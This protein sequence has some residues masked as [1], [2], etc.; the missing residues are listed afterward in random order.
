MFRLIVLKGN[1]MTSRWC[2]N[3]PIATG[4][5]AWACLI[6]TQPLENLCQE[7]KLL[8]I[9]SKTSTEN[10]STPY[11]K[12]DTLF[13][14]SKD[15]RVRDQCRLEWPTRKFMQTMPSGTS[16]KSLN[17]NRSSNL[18]DFRMWNQRQAHRA[19]HRV[20]WHLDVIQRVCKDLNSSE[21]ET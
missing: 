1:I 4:W 21:S 19:L 2:L 15:K 13:G 20:T 5:W 12:R 18:S 16:L 11:N 6:A 7:M 8:P 3:A 10:E 9:F 17:P 14:W